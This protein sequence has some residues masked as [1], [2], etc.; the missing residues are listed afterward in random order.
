MRSVFKSDL[1]WWQCCGCW[2]LSPALEL[3]ISVLITVPWLPVLSVTNSNGPRVLSK[4]APLRFVIAVTLAHGTLK[5]FCV[6]SK[7]TVNLVLLGTRIFCTSCRRMCPVL[8]ATS[9]SVPSGVS[10]FQIIQKKNK[11]ETWKKGGKEWLSDELV[12]EYTGIIVVLIQFSKFKT[13]QGKF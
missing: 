10:L 4:S 3:P 11:W 12:E 13:L 5:L 7:K 8:E 2:A 6:C 1:D 9:S